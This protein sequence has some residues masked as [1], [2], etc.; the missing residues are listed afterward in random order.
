M[1]VQGEGRKHEGGRMGGEVEGGEGEEPWE[2]GAKGS[3]CMYGTTSDH[4][5]SPYTQPP[6]PQPLPPPSP[7]P[8]LPPTLPH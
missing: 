2:R 5:Q 7:S 8:F 3:M 6:P 4:H 1:G